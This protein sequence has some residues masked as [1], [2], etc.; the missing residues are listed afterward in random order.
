LEEDIL[1]FRYKEKELAFRLIGD[2]VKRTEGEKVIHLDQLLREPLKMAALVRS[3]LHLNRT[4]FARNCSVKKVDKETAQEFLE[5]YHIMGSTQSA[6]NLGLYTGD[7]LIALAS[8][9][10]GRKMDRLQPEQRSFELI[11]FCCKSGITVTGGLTKLVKHFCEERKAGDVMTYVEKELS[12]GRSFI[13]AG[14]KKYDET[15]PNYFLVDR[16]TYERIPA[17]RE[18]V[19]DAKRFYLS[20]NGGNL[21]MVYTPEPSKR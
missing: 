19:Y 2:S 6:Y 14:F 16:R 20:H 12:D 18:A 3:R 17:K 15:E 13:S 4:V 9:S 11:R 21:K 1:L 5:K 10:K 8:F 7:T